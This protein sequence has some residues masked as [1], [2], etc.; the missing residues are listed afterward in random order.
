MGEWFYHVYLKDQSIFYSSVETQ[1]LS[2][3]IGTNKT[4]SES[5]ALDA[6]KKVNEPQE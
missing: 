5:L 6:F 3:S 1:T 2:F 4:W